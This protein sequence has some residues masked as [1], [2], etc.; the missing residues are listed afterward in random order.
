MAGHRLAAEV[1]SVSANTLPCRAL[2]AYFYVAAS[3]KAGDAPP[4][5]NKS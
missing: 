5:N 3:I 2:R 1:P 4:D